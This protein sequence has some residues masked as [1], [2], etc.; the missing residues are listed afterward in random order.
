MVG[1]AHALPGAVSTA[2]ASTTE[3]AKWTLASHSRTQPPSPPP[4]TT[5]P[6]SPPV[7]VCSDEAMAL[8]R[9]I[10][11]DVA[12]LAVRLGAMD[13]V[14][15]LEKCGISV[16]YMAVVASPYKEA[17]GQLGIPVH[18]A[19]AW[20]SCDST[21]G[22]GDVAEAGGDATRLLDIAR[23]MK[24]PPRCVLVVTGHSETCDDTVAA[25]ATLGM[26]CVRIGHSTAR[27]VDAASTS[28]AGDNAAQALSTTI[29]FPAVQA[30]AQGA[31]GE[32]RVLW[33]SYRAAFH[34]PCVGAAFLGFPNCLDP[35]TLCF[36]PFAIKRDVEVFHE[37]DSVLCLVN[38]KPILP[39]TDLE[40][41]A[42]ACV[43]F[44]WW[45]VTC[46]AVVFVLV[47]PGHC[48]VIPRRRV[49]SVADLSDGELSALWIV[50]KRIGSMLKAYHG[51]DALTLAIQDGAAAGQ[52]VPHVHIHILPRKHGDFEKNDQV[53]PT[54]SFLCLANMAV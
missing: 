21:G 4:R 37:T 18:S 44:R 38:L 45:S 16:G 28:A 3:L 22:H 5:G 34:V 49:A 19:A 2:F 17:L 9:D 48:L 30:F 31:N 1:A 42:R 52:T 51:A 7:P 8:A 39:G 14:R 50:A 40:P 6:A 54:A 12:R 15:A 27:G 11:A 53:R 13:A 25:A 46:G 32:R 35:S 26:A 36:G 20:V 10:D 43:C 47:C 29:G 41:H 23:A 24:V 33:C